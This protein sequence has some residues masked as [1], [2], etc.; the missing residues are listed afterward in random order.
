MTVF[1]LIPNLA[2][3]QKKSPV[4]V[5]LEG[6]HQLRHPFSISGEERELQLCDLTPG[7]TY[8][9]WAVEFGC[10]ATLRFPGQDKGSRYFSFVAKDKCVDLVMTRGSEG[11]TCG[12]KQFSLSVRCDDCKNGDGKP[13]LANLSTTQ[14]D[15][16]YLI[17][18]VFIG[19]GCF[20]VSGVTAVGAPAALGEFFGGSAS[21]GIDHGVII[22][23]GNIANAPGPNDSESAGNGG[24]GGS[25][26][27]LLLL[28]GAN[29]F[30]AV[31]I[32]FNFTPTI[33]TLTFNYAFASEEYCEFAPPVSNYNDVFGF[34]ISGPGIAGGFMFNGDNIAVL[35]GGST[36]ASIANINPVT[37][38]GYF[39]PNQDGSCGGSFNMTDIQFDGFSVILSAVANVIPC[40]TYHIRLL[41]GDAIDGIYDSAVFLQA[42]SFSAGGVGT[43]EAYSEITGTN[44]VY[45]NCND[46][47][48]IF[49]RA[50]GDINLPVIIEYTI[51]PSSTAT[52]GVDYVPL[53]GT[54]IIP[55][56]VSDF[57]LPV[58]VINDGIPE[59]IE[60]IIISLQNACSCSSFNITLEIADPPDLEA[61]MPDQEICAATTTTLEPTV[62]GGIENGTFNYMWSTGDGSPVITVNPSETT[63]YTVTVTDQCGTSAVATA[64][65][66]VIELPTAFISGGG[67]ICANQPGS[68]TPV[69]VD[70]TGTGPWLFQ[71]TIDG[72]FQDPI[73]TS[74][75]PY[76]ITATEPGYYTV[77]SVMSVLGGC[78]GPADGIV[79]VVS[80][81]VNAEAFATP[82]TCASGG[83]TVTV[84]A[85][86]GLPSYFFTWSNGAPSQP[87]I[88]NLLPGTYSVTVSDQA[89]CTITA[90]ATVTQAPPLTSSASA[91]GQV[92]CAN[93]NGGSITVSS[94]GGT[95]PYSYQWS[96][97]GIP[98]IPNPTG[99]GAGTYTVTVTDDS[100]CTATATATVNSNTTLPT[101]VAAAN[102]VITCSQ[103]TSALNGSGSSTG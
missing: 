31:G 68:S 66:Q 5:K 87:T 19:G 83:G 78:F 44:L 23:C 34:F 102:G 9:L 71:Y 24:M 35:P 36:P 1:S 13:K 41:V 28:A 48:F 101:A 76:V 103:G 37:N 64:T 65:V 92:T 95:T 29:V 97:P 59:G 2:I 80:S 43:G 20:D 94:S 86:G 99:L 72:V 27:D 69:S 46:G 89:G 11:E 49:H 16:A 54:F 84:D 26:P 77:V 75:N 93:P 8:T 51:L 42:G 52:P 3:S 12:G 14:Q 10:D 15:A 7:W 88:V 4:V 21:I 100:N 53:S 58:N 50:A 55:P 61:T 47:Q 62:S 67:F 79:Q 82:S 98:N 22:E 25:D 90:S 73:E 60:T 17:N 81:D 70:F 18:E 56:G 33:G 30:D 40:Q 6:R 96:Q 74:N 57:G 38:S 85:T 45:E 63:V 91:S 32:E 39:V